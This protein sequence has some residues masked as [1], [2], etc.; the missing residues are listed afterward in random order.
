MP[1]ALD[2]RLARLAAEAAR[3]DSA[4]DR[5]RC[6][7]RAWAAVCAVVHGRLM[8]SGVDPRRVRALRSGTA[9]AAQLA[10]LGDTAELRHADDEFAADDGDGLAA[11]FAEKIG[12]VARRYQ[13]GQE[14][15]FANASLAELFA[16][17]C[18]SR[19]S[20]APPPAARSE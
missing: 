10:N 2:T 9:A 19:A 16:W 15:D 3:A 13:G 20:D 6:A 5:D 12:K 1:R 14:P 4:K 17:S 18:V 7:L 11:M 8:Q